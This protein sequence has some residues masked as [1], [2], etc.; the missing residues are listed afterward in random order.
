[1]EQVAEQMDLP[2]L[3]Q[4]DVYD[5]PGW[6]KMVHDLVSRTIKGMPAAATATRAVL[7]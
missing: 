3:W 4:D 6:L 2:M 1:M 7:P 5:L